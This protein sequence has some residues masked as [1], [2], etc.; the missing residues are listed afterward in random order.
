MI[1]KWIGSILLPA[2]FMSTAA[3]ATNV[4]TASQLEIFHRY[5]VNSGNVPQGIQLDSL[6]QSLVIS[7]D[8]TSSINTSG[9]NTTDAPNVVVGNPFTDPVIP[10]SAQRSVI[11][12][13][14]S[15]DQTAAAGYAVEITA[16]DDPFVTSI[17]E[18]IIDN[19]G[20]AQII[21]A[22]GNNDAAANTRYAVERGYL[23]ENISNELISFNIIGILEADL[24]ATA[25]GDGS[26]ARAAAG[27]YTNFDGDTGVDIAYLALSPY[28]RGITDD[29]LG[30]SVSDLF[31]AD[32]DG[33]SF[34][35][36]TTAVSDGALTDAAF[37][38]MFSY[39]FGISM[40]P[41]TSLEMLTG[42]SQVNGVEYVVPVAPVPLPASLPFL[43]ASLSGLFALRLR[44][45][46]KQS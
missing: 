14:P 2:T 15:G 3:I 29:D 5:I 33:L 17:T 20:G 42:F 12:T 21:S 11:T 37:D 16:I 39:R 30:A 6:P 28:L 9:T 31:T 46:C 27:M 38:M 23:F 24:F 32:M 22:N 26:I 36:S 41:G 13:V 4:T 34:S 40:Q 1:K 8:V 19:S 7:S 10:F 45:T 35:A 25:N 18:R 44:H 43:A